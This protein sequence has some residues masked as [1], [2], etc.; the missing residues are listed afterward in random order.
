MGA[1]ATTIRIGNLTFDHASYDAEGDVLCL[2][3]GEPQAAADSEETPEGHA[4]RFD[5]EGNPI[6]I[7]VVNAR[8]LLNRD[9]ALRITIP[10]RFEVGSDTLAPALRAA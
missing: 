3:A 6:G 2:H 10:E 8:W 9:G 4:L 5:A 1:L 7:T